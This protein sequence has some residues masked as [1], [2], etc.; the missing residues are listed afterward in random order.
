MGETN[1]ILKYRRANDS[2]LC[3]EC[4]SENQ[5]TRGSCSVCG[6][7]TMGRVTIVRAWNENDEKPPVTPGAGPGVSGWGTPGRPPATP[8]WT[9]GG[10]HSPVPVEDGPHY[11]RVFLWTIAIV[12]IIIF[13]CFVIY[14]TMNGM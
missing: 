4:D 12:A 10:G 3:P 9:A 2:W 11:G 7:K 8:S 6:H 13:V 1:V 14:S 5:L